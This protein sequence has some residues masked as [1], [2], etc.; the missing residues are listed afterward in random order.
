MTGK[1]SWKKILSCVRAP[2]YGK[3]SQANKTK[4]SKNIIKP[5]CLAQTINWLK[6]LK[7][8]RVQGLQRWLESKVWTGEGRTRTPEGRRRKKSPKH[9]MQCSY[10]ISKQ[11]LELIIYF[12]TRFKKLGGIFVSREYLQNVLLKHAGRSRQTSHCARNSSKK[13]I[14][15]FWF[16]KNTLH[17]IL[18][19]Y[20]NEL[21]V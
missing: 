12:S 5:C 9:G 13:K 11:N 18:S 4:H 10:W 15:Q 7:D 16:L 1:K 8:L 21:S 6:R 2:E 20:K 17:K 19:Q 3:H 14:P